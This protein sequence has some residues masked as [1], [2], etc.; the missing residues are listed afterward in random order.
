M[1]RIEPVGRFKQDYK[2]VKKGRHGQMI[3]SDLEDIVAQLADDVP[4]AANL[5]DHQLT[6]EWR[7]H[8][9]CHI[10]PDLVLIY[11][12]PDDERLQLVRLTSHAELGW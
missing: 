10:K 9:D 4:L 3:L 5:R 7:N 8:R 12:K 11:R 6:G 1:R 2:R